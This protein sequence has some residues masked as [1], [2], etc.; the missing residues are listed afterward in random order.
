MHYGPIHIRESSE[1][2][3]SEYID[4]LCL[5]DKWQSSNLDKDQVSAQTYD[6]LCLFVSKK[7]DIYDRMRNRNTILKDKYSL[8]KEAHV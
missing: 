8:L 1:E 2:E 3:I 6:D 4:K 7:N 5:M